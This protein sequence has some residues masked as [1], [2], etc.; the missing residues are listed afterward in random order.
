MRSWNVICGVLTDRRRPCP[1]WL[2]YLH[3]SKRKASRPHWS[4][5]HT[6]LRLY[7]TDTLASTHHSINGL[8]R[9]ASTSTRWRIYT[10]CCFCTG[11]PGWS[12]GRFTGSTWFLFGRHW[13]HSSAWWPG[14]QGHHCTY[15]NTEQSTGI[16]DVIV[17]AAVL[18][19]R[20][21]FYHQFIIML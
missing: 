7:I 4:V 17:N 16:R 10:N 1:W 9:S 13:T 18:R 21:V 15:R 5:S 11:S 14:R 3:Q 12:C 19:Q 20:I 6:S 8:S 2:A